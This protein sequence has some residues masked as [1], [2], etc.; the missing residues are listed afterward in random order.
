M[1][2]DLVRTLCHISFLRVFNGR[3]TNFLAQS[4][5]IASV[6]IMGVHTTKC[7]N[8]HNTQTLGVVGLFFLQLQLDITHQTNS[9]CVY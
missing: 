4:F 6:F 8:S 3:T 1:D 9:Q 5:L 7:L 2:E